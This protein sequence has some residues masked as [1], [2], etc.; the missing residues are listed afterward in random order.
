MKTIPAIVSVCVATV[1]LACSNVS[2]RE[3]HVSKTGNDSAAGTRD[4]PYLTIDKAAQAAQPGETVIVHSGTY[5]EWVKPARGGTGEKKR[6]TY[7]AA[8]GQKVL[9]KGSERITTWKKQEGGVWKVDLPN[10][11]F[12]DYNPYA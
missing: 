5:R 2:G 3:I 12:G 6:S 7:R 10:S 8:A 4:K 9:I 11:F 1:F